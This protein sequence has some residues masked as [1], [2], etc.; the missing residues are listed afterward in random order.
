MGYLQEQEILRRGEREG[1]D[2][3]DPTPK[4]MGAL[5]P[6]VKSCCWRQTL[7]VVAQRTQTLLQDKELGWSP[8]EHIHSFKT[9]SKGAAPAHTRSEVRRKRGETSPS[10]RYRSTDATSPH[11]CE[12]CEH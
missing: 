12:Y 11:G 5:M 8:K 2:G 4:N 1:G 7:K 9:K 3:R 10:K 6:A